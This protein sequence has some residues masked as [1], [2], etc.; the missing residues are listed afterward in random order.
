MN[1]Q[2]NRHP[3]QVFSFLHKFIITDQQHVIRLC[4]FYGW[5]YIYMRFNIFRVAEMAIQ[6]KYSIILS[7][8]TLSN[9]LISILYTNVWFPARSLHLSQTIWFF[10]HPTH[11]CK[12]KCIKVNSATWHFNTKRSLPVYQ[13]FTSLTIAAKRSKRAQKDIL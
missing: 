7:M 1:S 12:Q 13:K 11:G 4:I 2:D 3:T 9:K 6:L 10:D 8:V 5:K